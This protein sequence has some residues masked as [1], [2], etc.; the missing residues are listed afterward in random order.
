MKKTAFIALTAL[1]MSACAQDMTVVKGKGLKTFMDS[2]SYA[3]GQ[4]IYTS[5]Q[6][7]NLDFN[8]DKVTQAMQNADKGNIVFTDEQMQSLM[9]RFQIQMNEKQKKQFDDNVAAGKDYVMKVRNN[10]SVY[11]TESG[12]SYIRR[13]AGNGKKPTATDRVKVHYVGKLIDGTVFDSSVERGEPITFA[14]NQV[15]KGW[16]EGLQLMDE[17]SKYT[18]YIPQELGYGA[19][20]VGNIPPGSTLVFD[21]EL[22]EINPK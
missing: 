19:Q 12:L 3:I 6:R 2:V 20:A 22:L 11:T 1:T 16:T 8:I 7:Q 18:L 10:K 5:W 4:D 14:L 9:Q 17:G 15:I 21:V 13:K